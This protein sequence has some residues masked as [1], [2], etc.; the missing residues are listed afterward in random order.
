[1]QPSIG[2]QLIQDERR[3][4]CSRYASSMEARKIRQ[5]PDRPA[6]GLIVQDGGTNEDPVKSAVSDDRFLPVLVCVDLL[7]QKRKDHVVE[8]EATVPGTIP[9]AHPGD[10]EVPTSARIAVE[11]S[12]TWRKGLAG[13]P[14]ALTTAS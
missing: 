2:M 11:R 5:G 4:V 12:V 9:G 10:G 1:M 14:S 13:V 8:E 7:Q 6:P 3:N